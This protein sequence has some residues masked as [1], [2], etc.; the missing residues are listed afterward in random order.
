MARGARRKEADRVAIL[1]KT[2]VGITSVQRRYCVGAG[3]CFA[4]IRTK[5]GTGVTRLLRGRPPRHARCKR[6]ETWKRRQRFGPKPAPSDAFLNL[7]SPQRAMAGPACSGRCHPLPKPWTLP[8]L[9]P[10]ADPVDTAL[11]SRPFR[12]RTI[13]PASSWGLRFGPDPEEPIP[14]RHHPEG[15]LRPP[16]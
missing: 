5:R 8:P 13:R 6:A 12:A 2:R 3:G 16:R 7:S 10:R 11:S 4:P 1:A 9:A 15:P 14:I